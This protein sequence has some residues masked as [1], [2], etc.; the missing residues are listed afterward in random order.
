MTNRP[1]LAPPAA[2]TERFSDFEWVVSNQHREHSVVFRLCRGGASELFVKVQ[3]S[4]EYP[5]L[6]AEAERTRWA[7]GHV[8]VPRVVERG[9]E[10]GVEWLVTTPLP[11]RDATDPGLRAEPEH[12]TRLLAR[13]LRNLHEELPIEDCPFDFRTG[14]ALEHVHRRL[15]AGLI[16]PDRDFHTEF[17]DLTAAEAVEL[18]ESTRPEAEDL[19]VCHGDFCLP[20]VLFRGDE[21]SGYVD[22]GELG[23]ADRWW[24]LA[25]ATWSLTWNLG[26]G[27]EALFLEEY[28]IAL[29]PPRSTFYR[30]MYDLVS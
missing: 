6:A 28:G 17:A 23:V 13:A 15:S 21:L 22:L 10:G 14:I 27:Y 7:V 2:L 1:W 19:V 9:L 18:L 16:E 5:S 25:V 3:P 12:L 30:L 24:D 4:G 26:S 29:D 20:N 8:P 11:G